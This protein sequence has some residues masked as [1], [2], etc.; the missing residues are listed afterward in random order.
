MPCII[1]IAIW[2]PCLQFYPHLLDLDRIQARK[3]N[4]CTEAANALE[5]K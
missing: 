5:E 3:L 1:S 4:P 2:H